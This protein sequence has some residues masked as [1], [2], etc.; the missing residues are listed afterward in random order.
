MRFFLVSLLAVG[1]V[2]AKLRAHD[3]PAANDESF[4]ALSKEF[5]EA[6]AKFRD[7]KLQEAIKAQ[8]VAKEKR[9]AADEGTGVVR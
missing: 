1:L 5:K 6:F 2:T 4:A 7:E 9:K 8:E 3:Q